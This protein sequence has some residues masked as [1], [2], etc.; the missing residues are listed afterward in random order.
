MGYKMKNSLDN[1]LKK[2]DMSKLRSKQSR[3]SKGVSEY[4]HFSKKGTQG[5]EPRV[6]YNMKN[7]P[8][9]SETRPLTET[10]KKK[11]KGNVGTA[12]NHAKTA[13][14]IAKTVN[15]AAEKI[16]VGDATI[17]SKK[18]EATTGFTSRKV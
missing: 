11:L 6:E 16:P 14:N 10:E 2:T 4:Q 12:P 17:K 1:L 8:L 3:S 7:A 15:K 18:K 5:D 13:I 9:R